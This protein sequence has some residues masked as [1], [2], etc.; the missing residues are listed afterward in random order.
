[1]VQTIYLHLYLTTFSQ[2]TIENVCIEFAVICPTSKSVN[3]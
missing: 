3:L 1:M 2:D